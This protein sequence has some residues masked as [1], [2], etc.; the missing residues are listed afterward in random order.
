MKLSFRWYGEDDKVTLENIRQIPGMHSIVTAVYTSLFSQ[1]NN[2]S[3]NEKPT[4]N[5]IQEEAIDDNTIIYPGEDGK[6]KRKMFLHKCLITAMVIGIIS[7]IVLVVF[8]FLPC[9]KYAIASN[10]SAEGNYGRAYNTIYDLSGEKADLL[11]NYYL[12]KYS[13]KK[14]DFYEST[15]EP[16]EDGEYGFAEIGRSTENPHAA[17]PSDVIENY[18]QNFEDFTECME[19]ILPSEYYT[20][21]GY[22]FGNDGS[23]L[24]DDTR[25]RKY[26]NDKLGILYSK[27]DIIDDIIWLKNCIYSVENSN[28]DIDDFMKCLNDAYGMYDEMEALKNG[29]YF[30]PTHEIELF[31]YYDS[32]LMDALSVY[33]KYSDRAFTGFGGSKSNMEWVKGI[34]QEDIDNG[35][36]DKRFSFSQFDYNSTKYADDYMRNYMQIVIFYY[37]LNNF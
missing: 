15:P 12:T 31:E 13:I 7:V 28:H 24:P 2:E 3:L 19:E 27:K 22:V 10:Y 34:I 5:F 18:L 6:F 32:R 17:N 36:G 29:K 20:N 35:A 21:S 8:Y 14:I 30:I 11:R 37:Y 16:D 25:A 9:G 23:S 26:L 33:Q 4:E 1:K